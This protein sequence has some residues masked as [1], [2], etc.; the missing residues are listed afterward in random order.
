MQIFLIYFLTEIF[1]QIGNFRKNLQ[2]MS[3]YCI[4]AATGR[5]LSLIYIS[6]AFR[7]LA[8]QR[9]SP[10]STQITEDKAVQENAHACRISTPRDKGGSDIR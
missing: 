9:K 5:V 6:K 2:G 3:A 4:F 10:I 7:A 1:L 8:F